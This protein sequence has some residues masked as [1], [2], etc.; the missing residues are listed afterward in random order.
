[1]RKDGRWRSRP[2]EKPLIDS[3][4]FTFFSLLAGGKLIVLLVPCICRRAH[5]PTFALSEI[6]KCSVPDLLFN[7][8]GQFRNQ[9][10]RLPCRCIVKARGA[11]LKVI[12]GLDRTSAAP[13]H[14]CHWCFSPRSGKKPSL[15]KVDANSCK[16]QVAMNKDRARHLVSTHR[17]MMIT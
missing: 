9:F 16:I 6:K 7:I 2:T 3:D 1:M 5:R 4:V 10:L 17:S 11:N 8:I 13:I 15:R 12:L 14:T